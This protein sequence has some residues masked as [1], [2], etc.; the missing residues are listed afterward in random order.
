MGDAEDST[1]CVCVLCGHVMTLDRCGSAG[2]Q[3]NG[4][5]IDLCHTDDHD[6]YQIQSWRG[7]RR[8]RPRITPGVQ[9]GRTAGEAV[10]TGHTGSDANR[11]TD[12][13]PGTDTAA[14][15]SPLPSIQDAK[16]KR[17]RNGRYFDR[18]GDARMES[19]NRM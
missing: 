18:M 19:D 13:R 5:V 16:R 15:A 17:S 6:C 9:Q 8:I 2:T 7:V 4:H 12:P 14:P 11:V 1:E 3:K 10:G